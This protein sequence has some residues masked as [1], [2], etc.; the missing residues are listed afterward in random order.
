MTD[1]RARLTDR[2]SRMPLDPLQRTGRGVDIDPGVTIGQPRGH[3]SFML[4]SHVSSAGITTTTDFHPSSIPTSVMLRNRSTPGEAVSSSE[5]LI[6]EASASRGDSH[7]FLR[8]CFDF[9]SE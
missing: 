9:T 1:R 8:A 5:R 2:R 6:E 7:R 4:T 3:S